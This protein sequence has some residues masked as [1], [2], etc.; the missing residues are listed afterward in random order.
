MTKLMNPISLRFSAVFLLAIFNA[1]SAYA[2][3]PPPTDGET[4][5][6][7]SCIYGLTPYIPGCPTNS[8]ITIP[9]TG[10]GIIAVIDGGNDPDALVELNQFSTQFGLN[11]LSQCGPGVPAP[12]FQTYYANGSSCTVGTAPSAVNISEPEI[13]IEWSHAMA[14]NAS[15][16]MIQTNGWEFANMLEGIQCANSILQSTGG[17]ISFSAS[18]PENEPYLGAQELSYDS[19]F[20]VPGII[21]VASSG[22]Y[23]APARY[24][25]SSPYVIAAGGTMIER[26]KLGNYID[27]V[28]WFNTEI[29]CKAGTQCR[30]GASGGPSQY[31]PRPAYQNSVQKIVGTHRGTPDI[32]FV[33]QHVAV[34][35][36]SY[37]VFTDGNEQCCVQP[38]KSNP[39]GLLPCQSFSNCDSGYGLWFNTGGT[40]LA[41]PALTGIMNTAHSGATTSTQELMTIYNGALKNYHSYWTDITKGNNGFPALQGYDFATGLGVPRGYSGK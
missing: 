33:A 3:P 13:D 18:Y 37:A 27:Q 23:Q 11:T 36:C 5:Q 8:G 34:F 2:I 6:S 4:P 32:S 22:D 9:N 15:I 19:N 28:T 14:P 16:Y 29:P 30:T 25:A 24:P 21:Y 39:N 7:L 10:S 1:Q 12:C 26:D 31:E 20:Q 38:G 17:Y 40:S 35:C 41:A